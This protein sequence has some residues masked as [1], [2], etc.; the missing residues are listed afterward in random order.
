MPGG[1]IAVASDKAGLTWEFLKCDRQ[2][3]A[4][5]LDTTFSAFSGLQRIQ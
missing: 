2:A 3:V 4:R 5:H 1:A